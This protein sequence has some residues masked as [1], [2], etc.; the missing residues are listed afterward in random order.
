MSNKTL[1]IISGGAE[2]VP[3]I[4]RAKALGLHVVVSDYDPQAPGFAFADDTLIASTYDIDQT[5]SVA[6]HFHETKRPI[7]GVICMAADVP[8]TVAHVAADLG[9]PGLSVETARLAADKLAMKERFAERGIAIPWFRAVGSV[10]EVQQALR[11]RGSDLVIKPVDSRGARGVLHIDSSADLDWAFRHAQSQSPT[12]RVML[13]SYQAGPQISTESVMCAGQGY[14]VGFIDRNYEFLDRYAPY[15]IE[16]G[17]EQPSVLS[18]SQRS[19][20]ISLVEEAARAMGIDNG[21]AK[22]DMVLTDE[23]PKVIEIAARLSGGWMSSDQIPLATGVDIVGA[24]IELAVGKT[25]NQNSL[26]PQFHKGVAIRYFFPAPGRVTAIRNLE[27]YQALPWVHRLGLFV[28][29][30]D[31]LQAVTDHTRRAGFVITIGEDRDQAV[32][33]A[34]EVVEGLVIETLQ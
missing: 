33:R 29:P 34:K 13:E 14:T 2:A 25:P 30:G 16:N 21:I 19:A 22:G 27:K 26:Q 1:L 20:V 10:A 32:A 7:D 28:A 24:A 18:D 15:M 23:G 3:G 9:L 4:Q 6:R 31:E 17:G 8:L 12:D 5:V 11:E